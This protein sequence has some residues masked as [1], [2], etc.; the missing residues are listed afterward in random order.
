MDKSG[1]II[2]T[3]KVCEHVWGQKCVRIDQ[4][5]VR[6]FVI[7]TFA[8]VDE[9]LWCFHSNETSSAV[10]SQGPFFLQW[11][12]NFNVCGRNP[13]VLPSKWNLLRRTFAYCYLNLT[14]LQKQIWIFFCS[15]LHFGLYPE[16]KDWWRLKNA[17][18]KSM[19]KFPPTGGVG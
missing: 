11:S 3:P 18:F 17:L 1:P 19:R 8:S 9:I 15:D 6:R 7:I 16:W 14:I 2:A 12:C 4:V 10:L 5:M 13:V